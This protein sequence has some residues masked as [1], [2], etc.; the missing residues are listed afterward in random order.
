MVRVPFAPNRRYNYCIAESPSHQASLGARLFLP[1]SQARSLGWIIQVGNDFPPDIE[2]YLVGLGTT[3][4]ADRKLDQQSMRGLLEY[5]D[6]VFG[7][8][9]ASV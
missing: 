9:I 1:A 3:L 5:Q 4:V 6:S 2:D 8:M 7:S